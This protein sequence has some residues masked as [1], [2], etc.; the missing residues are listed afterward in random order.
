MAEKIDSFKEK[1]ADYTL[2][3]RRK[4]QQNYVSV[5]SCASYRALG[6]RLMELRQIHCY[7]YR[8]VEETVGKLFGRK[9]VAMTGELRKTSRSLI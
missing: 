5:L 4:P 9:Q 1:I 7:P 3:N 2:E 8:D 6:S